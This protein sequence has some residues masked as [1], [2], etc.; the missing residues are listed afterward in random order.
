[1]N[2]SIKTVEILNHAITTYH[3]HLS[4]QG[5]IS[6]GDIRNQVSRQMHENG[7]VIFDLNVPGHTVSDVINGIIE[8]ISKELQLKDSDFI[9]LSESLKDQLDFLPFRALF[10]SGANE[11]NRLPFIYH[12]QFMTIFPIK[13]FKLIV[14]DDNEQ[15]NAFKSEFTKDPHLLQWTNVTVVCINYC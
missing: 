8:S 5:I 1:M 14:L 10:V 11:L 6:E 13:K 12:R 9:L 15:V 4:R 2:D 3:K 7:L